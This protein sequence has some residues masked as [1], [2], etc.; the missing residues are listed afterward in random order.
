MT[1][2]SFLTL[3]EAETP[4]ADLPDVLRALWF[5]KRGEWD[6]AHETIQENNDRKSAA[7]HAY[8]H[9]KEGDLWNARYWYNTAKK[10]PFEG[11]LDKEWEALARELVAG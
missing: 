3:C 5:D 10:K 1:I 2:E 11:S 9:R 4:P 8:L 6:K 7:I